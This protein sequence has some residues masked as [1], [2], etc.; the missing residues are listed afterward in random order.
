MEGTLKRK[1]RAKGLLVY[2]AER[3][4]TREGTVESL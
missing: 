3:E 1:R 4:R 2:E